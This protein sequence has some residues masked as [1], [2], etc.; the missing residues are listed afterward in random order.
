ML[1]C[2]WLMA[3]ISVATLVSSH[4]VGCF[5]KDVLEGRSPTKVLSDNSGCDRVCSGINTD[6]VFEYHYEDDNPDHVF[7]L[8]TNDPPDPY[9]LLGDCNGEDSVIIT[10]PY[11]RDHGF[12]LYGGC[13]D[14]SSVISSTPVDSALACWDLCNTYP[15][16]GVTYNIST[17][18]Y[19]PLCNCYETNNYPEFTSPGYGCYYEAFFPYFHT[20]QPSAVIRRRMR[21]KQDFLSGHDL[22]L[23]PSGMTACKVLHGEST[24]YECLDIQEELESCGGC[25]YG[26]FPSHGDVKGTKGLFRDC[27][28]IIGVQLGAVTCEKGHCHITKCDEGYEFS[29]HECHLIA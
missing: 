14:K 11:K 3:F 4:F 18:P 13:H 19:T 26:E 22:S 12:D 21:A 8:C 9:W 5:T 6:F 17:T 25:R 15:F 24:A 10:V 20:V 28:S 27:T 16:A 23:C 7:C 2:F 29:D 1:S